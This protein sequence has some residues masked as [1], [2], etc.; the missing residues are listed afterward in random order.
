MGKPF[1]GAAD[2]D[3][4]LR[5]EEDILVS[6]HRTLHIDIMFGFQT[7]ILAAH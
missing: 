4:V 7:D 5:I 2:G 3:V 6:D 1:C